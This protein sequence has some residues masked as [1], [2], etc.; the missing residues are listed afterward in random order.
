[1]RDTGYGG[2][3]DAAGKFGLS[4]QIAALCSDKVNIAP[5]LSEHIADKFASGEH[6]PA[7]FAY[8]EIR[9]KRTQSD[10]F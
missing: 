7:M 6:I 8:P 1:M 2:I 4:E 10:G 5:A 9:A 3:R